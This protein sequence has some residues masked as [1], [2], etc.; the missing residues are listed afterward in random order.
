MNKPI[1]AIIISACL[2]SCAREALFPSSA[3]DGNETLQA[4]FAESRVK[5]AFVESVYSW[6]TGDRIRVAAAEGGTLDFIY[7]GAPS[8]GEVTFVKNGESSKTILFGD[9]GYAVYPSLSEGN[10]TVTAGVMTLNLKSSYSWAEGNIEAPMIAK[11]KSGEKL[12]FKHL[13]GLLKVSYTNV[14][15]DAAQLIVNTP[16]YSSTN[17]LTVTGWSGTFVSDTP[18][19]QAVAGEDGVVKQTFSPGTATDMTFYIPLPVGPGVEHKYP[20]ISIWLADSDGMAIPATARSATNLQIERSAIK[21]MPSI[22]VPDVYSVTTLI[23]TKGRNTALASKAGGAYSDVIFGCPRGMGWI[24]PGHTAFILDQA[25]NLRIWN[26]DTKTVSAPNSYGTSSYVPWN[27]AYKNGQV[28]FA[29]KAQGMVYSYNVS[30]GSFTQLRTGYSGKS[31]VDVKF[32]SAGNAYLAVWDNYAIY[33][34]DGG[35]FSAEPSATYGFSGKRP[36]NM[37]FDPYGALIVTTNGGQVIKVNTTTGDQELIAGTLAAN[38][39]D[40]GTSGYPRTAKFTNNLNALAITSGGV[41]YVADHYRLRKI[42]PG[43]S[44]YADAVVSTVAG[45]SQ[46]GTIRTEVDGTGSSATFNNIGSLLLS[47]DESVLYLTEQGSGYVRQVF[48]GNVDAPVK[49]K[50]KLKAAT[51]NI[52]FITDKDTGDRAWDTRKSKIVN[53]ISDYS[54]DVVGFQE[55]TSEQRTYLK[56]RLTDYSFQESAYADQCIAWKASKYTKLDWGQFWL[57]PDSETPNSRPGPPWIDVTIP[58]SRICIW[59]KLRD[60]SSGKEFLY[61]NTHLEVYSSGI[62][63]TGGLTEEELE[64]R[65]V[66]VRTKSAELLID[67]A[68]TLSGGIM[69]TILVGDMNSNTLEAGNEALKA[70]YTDAYYDDNAVNRGVKYGSIATYNGWEDTDEQAAKWYQR[71]DDIYYINGLHLE[72]YRTIRRNYDDIL[73]S[74][75]WPVTVDF[76]L[77]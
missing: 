54:F 42:T 70:Y 72:A 38:T 51:Y 15:D 6:M 32:D 67:R 52:R 71:V 60:N 23:G 55:S 13:T 75:H 5:T 46:A 39:M 45:G 25:Q 30:T 11:V 69:P 77:D 74:D 44:G 56:S 62:A 53:L 76:I 17:C 2:V 33:R 63:G 49:A 58:R 4:V 35:N 1:F 24:N 31:P 37:A 19:V 22:P 9:A 28:Y 47:P 64:E 14:P 41:I 61:M 21:P 8:A 66:T 18:Y 73:P 29:E 59:I 26:L 10:C 7:S 20:S 27:G 50:D 43:P 48:L 36:M 40:D 68:A 34:F 3:P 65:C 16:G 12:A 57:S